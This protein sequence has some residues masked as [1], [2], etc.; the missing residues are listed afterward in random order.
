[1]SYSG[2]DI[3]DAVVLNAAS[4]DRGFGRCVVLRKHASVLRRH[5]NRT[6]DRVVPP[7]PAPISAAAAAA[8]AGAIA[9]AGNDPAAVAAAAASAAASA[10]NQR[11][12]GRMRLLDA[13]GIAAV[14]EV[15]RPGDVLL[16]KQSPTN[17]KDYAP[18]PAPAALAAWRAVPPVAASLTLAAAGLAA[19]T[20]ATT[21]AWSARASEKSVGAG[22]WWEGWWGGCCCWGR[23]NIMFA[24]RRRRR[25]SRKLFKREGGGEKKKSSFPSPFRCLFLVGLCL[26]IAHSSSVT[27]LMR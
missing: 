24:V 7:P 13:D 25:K 16:N 10:T 2:Y 21:S 11:P 22:W 9:A 19:S 12:P 27:C 1:M 8:A 18:T 23:Q 3:E 4:L 17:T 15:V 5:T 20:R 6:A 26:R 14:G